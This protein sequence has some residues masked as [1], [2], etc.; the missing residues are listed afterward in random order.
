MISLTAR[1]VLAAVIGT[2]CLA[3]L[4][5]LAWMWHRKGKASRSVTRLRTRRERWSV[6]ELADLSR[7]DIDPQ[8]AEIRD[9]LPPGD[10]RDWQPPDGGA[11]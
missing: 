2:I 11:A 10:A 7:D 6:T 4:A 9:L 5:L 1:I 8:W 3:E